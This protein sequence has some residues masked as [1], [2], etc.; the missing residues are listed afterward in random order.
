MLYFKSGKSPYHAA[1][2][3]ANGWTYKRHEEIV[4]FFMQL[5]KAAG[6]ALLAA[7]R[8]NLTT[9]YPKIDTTGLPAIAKARYIP[10]VIIRDFPDLGTHTVLDISIAH[11]CGD[12]NQP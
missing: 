8:K 7:T 9:T 11:P 2:C 5:A 3:K 10:D 6:L 1:G 4:S 12:R